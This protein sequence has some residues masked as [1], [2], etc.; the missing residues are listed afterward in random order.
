[1]ANLFK[2]FIFKLRKD[3]TFRITLIV[4]AALAVGLSLIL[5]FIDLG[6]KNS[7]IDDFKLCTGQTLFVMSLSPAQNFGLAVPINLI[8]FTVLEFTQG[9]VLFYFLIW[10]SQMNEK[11][12]SIF[13]CMLGFSPVRLLH[14]LY[15]ALPL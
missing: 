14:Y 11:M 4:G 1:M 13:E 10:R 6:L 2:A 7:G 12:R 3:L 15:F 9:T 5:F 8:T